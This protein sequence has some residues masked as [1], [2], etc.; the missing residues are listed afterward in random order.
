MP[1]SRNQPA[2]QEHVSCALLVRNATVRKSVNCWLCR[3]AV[4]LWLTH[5]SSRH[6]LLVWQTWSHRLTSRQSTLSSCRLGCIPRYV[7]LCC[8]LCWSEIAQL[9]K[10]ANSICSATFWTAL[11]PQMEQ[12]NYLLALYQLPF[13]C[14]INF[15][16]PVWYQ[17]IILMPNG[18]VKPGLSQQLYEGMTF[19][20]SLPCGTL[21]SYWDICA[22]LGPSVLWCCWLGV[23][24]CIWPVKTEWWGT[25]KV[26]GLE[27]GADDLQMVHLM[28]LPPV[29]SCSS[30]IQYGLR[31]CCQLTPVVLEKGC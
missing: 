24:K 13:L 6:C 19:Y 2:N 12:M 15:C 30:K 10:P 26:I 22:Q 11:C 31:F 18:S 23:T 1:L 16:E 3:K 20:V 27:Q 29:I 25:G 17:C 14:D 7:I 21:A 4:C 8:S 9:G 28:P 5:S